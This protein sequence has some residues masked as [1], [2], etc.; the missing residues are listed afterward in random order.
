MK[1]SKW[2]AM[3][4]VCAVMATTAGCVVG[5]NSTDSS[6]N[7][8]KESWLSESVDEQEDSI[9]QDTGYS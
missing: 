8:I 3:L 7:D 5:F 9:L 2:I 1:V 6:S 4:A